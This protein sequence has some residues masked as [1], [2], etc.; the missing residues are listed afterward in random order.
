MTRSAFLLLFFFLV[1][2][3]GEPAFAQHGG[4]GG[5]AGRSFGTGA[6]KGSMPNT[7]NGGPQSHFGNEV[8]S[9]TGE[10]SN[11]TTVKGSPDVSGKKTV[12][13]LL[14]QNTKLSSNLQELLPAG[15]NIQDAAKG[16]DN[17][18]IRSCYARLS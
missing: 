17:L 18:A 5:V 7:S 9:H 8:K 1:L 15:T 6:G 12:D 14:T 13:E 4:F 10:S 3:F 2:C 16:F 11:V